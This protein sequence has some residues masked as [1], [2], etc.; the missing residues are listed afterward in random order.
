[1]ARLRRSGEGEG[2]E[3]RA[4]DW[5]QVLEMESWGR[6][7]DLCLFFSVSEGLT[8]LTFSFPL[9]TLLLALPTASRGSKETIFLS[10]NNE[11]AGSERWNGF[12]NLTQS[13]K[14]TEDSLLELWVPSGA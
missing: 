2:E 11:K 6:P 12:S 14:Q 13:W 5:G 8:D 4:G 7:G 9:P 10:F 1:M 3:L